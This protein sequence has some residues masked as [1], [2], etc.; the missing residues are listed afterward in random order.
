MSFYIALQFYRRTKPTR[1]PNES[2]APFIAAFERLNVSEDDAP[3]TVELKLG[4]VN[5]R[6]DRP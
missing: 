2:L 4:E 5:D 6:V 3:L 1:I